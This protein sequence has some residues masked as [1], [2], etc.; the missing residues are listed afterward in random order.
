MQSIP[1]PNLTL[2]LP[3]VSL[4]TSLKSFLLKVGITYIIFYRTV[5]NITIELILNATNSQVP[6]ALTLFALRMT[7]YCARGGS[8]PTG[9]QQVV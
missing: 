1:E 3:S 6:Q 9:Y 7:Y 5:I 4:G 2:L 8:N